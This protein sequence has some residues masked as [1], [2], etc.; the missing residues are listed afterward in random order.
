[1]VEAVQDRDGTSV[2]ILY[3]DPGLWSDAAF[4]ERFRA[5]AALLSTVEHP[6]VVRVHELAETATGSAAALITG[7]IG[8]TDLRA[9]LQ[10]SAPLS[11]E[12]A[13]AVMRGSLLGVGAARNAGVVHRDYQPANVWI[14][15]GGAVKVTGFGLAV[16][17][18]AM[19]PAPGTPAYM[20]PELWEGATAQSASDIY[21]VTA[22]FYECLT[23]S[24][25]FVADSVFE[26]QTMH[27]AAPIPVDDVPSALEPLILQG[28]AKT[29][30]ER[31]LDAATFVAEL[32]A[33]AAVAFGLEWEERGQRELAALVAGLS[34]APTAVPAAAKAGT[35]AAAPV[36]ADVSAASV[37]SAA[38]ASAEGMGR[39]TK[40]G[41]VVASVAVLGTVAMAVAFSPGKHAAAA[42]RAS[43]QTMAVPSDTATSGDAGSSPGIA[44]GG[45]P[46]PGAPRTS[47][48]SSPAAATGPTGT[49]GS[50]GLPPTPLT[51]LTALGLITNLNSTASGPGYPSQN[52]PPTSRPVTA[53]SSTGGSPTTPGA[54]PTVSASATMTSSTYSGPCPP[55][56]PPTGTV[57]FTVSGLTSA[58]PLAITYH[59][60]VVGDGTT[61]NAGGTGSGEVD[62]HNGTTAPQQFTIIDDPHDQKGL[63]GTVEITWTAAGTPGGSTSAGSV[64]I[65]CSP[66]GGPTSATSS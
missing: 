39:G 37:S 8:G 9:I 40:A 59:W 36:L 47:G 60:R 14:T 15:A 53:P 7:P 33:A 48:T 64:D 44:A 28:L 62:A 21:A 27:R 24:V 6:N 50:T 54:A 58:S 55:T 66:S 19:M 16:R 20:A 57:T 26:L 4:R 38:P 25:P 32:E 41:I 52:P 34:D 23:G 5:D 13:L 17:T 30:V 18:E 51:T 45:A 12:A 46:T 65:T 3:P 10:T 56:D 42:A 2:S 43:G 35:R 63:A 22:T 49:I 1:M 61:S 11:P 29:A 31:P